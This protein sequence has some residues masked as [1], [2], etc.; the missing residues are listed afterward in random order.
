[1]L[2]DSGSLALGSEVVHS[3]TLHH[4]V[5]FLAKTVLLLSFFDGLLS[6]LVTFLNFAF[7]CVH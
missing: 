6:S 5:L 7:L 3:K 4:L 1:M 2:I